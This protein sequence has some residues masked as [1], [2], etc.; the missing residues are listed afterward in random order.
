MGHFHVCTTFFDPKN[1]KGS[2]LVQSCKRFGVEVHNFG[3][4]TRFDSFLETKLKPMR[5][6]LSGVSADMALFLDG[7]DTIMV[8]EPERILASWEKVGGVV[9]GSELQTWPHLHLKPAMDEIAAKSGSKSPYKYIDTGFIMG[10][11]KEVIGLLDT[12]I[13]SVAHYKEKMPYL[14]RRRLEDDVGLFVLNL[15]DGKIDIN[16]DYK[17]KFI[18]AL[19]N[20]PA[21]DAYQVREGCL[22]LNL[23]GSYPHVVHC[24]GHRRSDRRRLLR[25]SKVLLGRCAWK[26]KHG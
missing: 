18:A 20:I 7:N 17:C 1:N 2:V 14:N 6:H 13:D 22:R 8:S 9:V 10:K 16:L 24:N 5:D 11:R 26:L 23:T 15:V 3:A 12:V 21:E 4:Q 25:L 19:R